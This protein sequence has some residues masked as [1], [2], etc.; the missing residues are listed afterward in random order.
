MNPENKSLL[1]RIFVKEPWENIA[2]A[3]II[4]GVVMLL[5]PYMMVLYT[6]SFNF[7]LG[8]TIAFLIVSHFPSGKF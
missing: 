1:R 2:S 8:G 6:Y 3:V 7:I 4:I 5:Q